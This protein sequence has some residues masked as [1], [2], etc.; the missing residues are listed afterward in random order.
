M[1]AL[2]RAITLYGATGGVSFWR[3]EQNQWKNNRQ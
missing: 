3:Y 1:N 2:T